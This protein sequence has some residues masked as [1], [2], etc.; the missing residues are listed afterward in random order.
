[1]LG[2]IEPVKFLRL[3]ANPNKLAALA[4]RYDK[5]VRSETI[6]PLQ[7]GINRNGVVIGHDGRHRAIHALRR[8]VKKLPIKI[9]VYSDGEPKIHEGLD[10]MSYLLGPPLSLVVMPKTLVGQYDASFR[11]SVEELR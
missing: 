6:G 10:G 2:S 5:G 1:M 9:S 3:C 4:A 7:L 8:G 11:V